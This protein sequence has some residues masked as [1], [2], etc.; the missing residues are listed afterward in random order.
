MVSHYLF[1]RIALLGGLWT[2][3]GMRTSAHTLVQIAAAWR[4]YR[5]GQRR[6]LR[7]VGFYLLV[8]L[9]TAFCETLAAAVALCIGYWFSSL[10]YYN[11]EMGY[12]ADLYLWGFV[13][14]PFGVCANSGFGAVWGYACVPWEGGGLSAP[15]F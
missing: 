11:I 2:T 8:E 13:R 5:R 3:V 15:T 4:R 1:Y 9:A 12:A 6:L 10:I 14:D 7:D